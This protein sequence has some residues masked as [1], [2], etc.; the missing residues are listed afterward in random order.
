MT[1]RFK[2]VDESFLQILDSY[3]ERL[4]H[5]FKASNPQLQ[6]PELT[7]VTQR[8]LDRLV[9]MRF[10]EDKLIETSELVQKLV[11]SQRPWRDFIAKSRRLN[12]VYNGIIFR[13]HELL[14]APDFKVDERTFTDICESLS[15]ARSP[16]L[17]SY[18]PIHILGSIYERFLG[19]TIV[20]EGA[21]AI[22]QDKP[23]VRKA[24]GVYYTPEYIVRYIVEN[25]VGQ[26]IE[27]KTPE[28]ISQMHFADISCGSGSFL[29]GVFDLLLRYHRTYY[30]ASKKRK[31]EGRRAGCVELPDKTLQLSLKQKRAILTN[32]IYGVDIDAQAVEVAQLSL[33]LKLLE[34]ETTASARLYQIELGDKLLPS[35]SKNIIGGNSLIDWDILSG[36][37]SISAKNVSSTR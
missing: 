16:Y 10:L 13:E 27:G 4:A 17:F 7:E 8:T 30:N 28:E 6:S 31:A 37:L 32:N 2:G 24:G 34:D 20:V 21:E 11:D 25:S 19:K 1:G 29:L 33:Y 35:L 14:D 23:E 3:R 18:I 12:D 36:K 22:V 15:H 26:L 5:T 9:F